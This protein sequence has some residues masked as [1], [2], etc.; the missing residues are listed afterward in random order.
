MYE[1]THIN[2]SHCDL[3]SCYYANLK[4]SYC[5]YHRENLSHSPNYSLKKNQHYCYESWTLSWNYH[6]E[7][8]SYS[9]NYSL[10]KSFRYDLRHCYYGSM[11]W[12]CQPM[13]HYD[14]TH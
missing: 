13:P 4:M 3:M 7:N 11:N 10:K 5:H 8:L 9:P 14:L 6:R 1:L 2:V 12:N